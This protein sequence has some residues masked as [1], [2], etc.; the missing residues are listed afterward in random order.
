[1]PLAT[2]NLTES[3]FPA[4]QKHFITAKYALP[5]AFS[6]IGLTSSVSA[7]PSAREI[8]GPAPVVPLTSE[9]APKLIV[10]DPLPDQLARGLVV[11]QYRTENLRIVPVFGPTALNVSP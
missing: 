6:F 4:K 11:I 7:Q 3:S 1:M 8:R 2:I 10:D 9:P 5:L